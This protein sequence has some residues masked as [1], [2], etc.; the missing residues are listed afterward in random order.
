M[1]D[2][3]KFISTPHPSVTAFCMKDDDKCNHSGQ[4][5]TLQPLPEFVEDEHGIRIYDD[6]SEEDVATLKV[7]CQNLHKLPDNYSQRLQVFE[8]D[9]TFDN[10]PA[11]LAP[12]ILDHL[13]DCL[14][15]SLRSLKSLIYGSHK[16]VLIP[17]P[18]RFVLPA[19]Q[20]PILQQLKLTSVQL[21]DND[22]LNQVFD[23]S[24]GSCQHKISSLT[25]WAVTIR[26]GTSILKSEQALQFLHTYPHL[27]VLNIRD[28]FS[29]GGLLPTNVPGP[30]FYS[31][32]TW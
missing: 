19:K 25:I 13:D 3:F 10:L 24:D 26:G 30:P 1:T 9:L 31:Q 27:T 11:A 22:L 15:T 16:G 17:L 20:C 2:W 5:E 7:I 28:E 6:L 23:S 8:L 29:I 14:Q 32:S 4:D 21:E 18:G 12:Q